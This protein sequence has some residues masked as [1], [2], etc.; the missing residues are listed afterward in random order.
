MSDIAK[1]AQRVGSVQTMLA[2][3]GYRT[4]R[5]S[6]SGQ[7]RGARRDERGI[8]GDL[9]AFAPLESEYPHLIVEVGGEKKAVA[10]SIFE[11]TRDPLPAGFAVLVA[12]CMPNRRWR[13]NWDGD[14]HYP[15][16]ELALAGREA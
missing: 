4:A 8:D 5:I 13:F 3:L 11:M 9:I 14:A 12:R 16:L 6:A 15:T 7:R 1:G 2:K 10:L